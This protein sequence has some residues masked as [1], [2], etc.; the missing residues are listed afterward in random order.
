[1]PNAPIVPPHDVRFEG[2]QVDATPSSEDGGRVT[3][4]CDVA[5]PHDDRV[6]PGHAFC[7]AERMFEL[8]RTTGPPHNTTAPRSNAH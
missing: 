8:L 7:R 4:P 1:M 3:V 5:R 2:C 6:V